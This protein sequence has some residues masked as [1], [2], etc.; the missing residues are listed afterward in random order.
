MYFDYV[1]RRKSYFR[2][3]LFVNL[4]NSWYKRKERKFT[5]LKKG[6]E[7]LQLYQKSSQSD[8][9]LETWLLVK[10]IVELLFQS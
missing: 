2:K 6:F 8:F 1:A 7:K 9:D 3:S 5:E 10:L 4:V